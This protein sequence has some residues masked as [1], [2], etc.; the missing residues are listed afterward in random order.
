MTV[1]ELIELLKDYDPKE[2]LFIWRGN[3]NVWFDYTSNLKIG[4]PYGNS[5]TNK[6]LTSHPLILSH[7][8]EKDIKDEKRLRTL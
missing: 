4:R 6:G 5:S 3:G 1:G 8:Y 2:Q 7:D